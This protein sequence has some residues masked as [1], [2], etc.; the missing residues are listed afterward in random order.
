MAEPTK[1]VRYPHISNSGQLAFSYH[2]DIWVADSDGSGARRLTAH[3]ARDTFPRFSPDGKWIAFNSDRMGNSDIWMVPTTGGVP[4]QLTHHSTDDSIQYWTPDG[5]SII[6]TTS[7]GAGPWGSPLYVVPTDGGLPEPLDMDRAAA[8]MMSQDGK[9]IAFNRSGFRY[10][11]KH[12]RGN[13]NTDIWIQNLATKKISQLT[14]T[15]VKEYRE[16]RQ[17]AHPMWGAD[18]QIY[19]MSERD[20]T[21]NIWKISPDGDE[22]TQVTSHKSDGVQYPSISPDGKTI[23][24]ENEF[25]L[26]KLPIEGGKPE[27]IAIDLSFDPKDNLVHV[28]ESESEARG[29][30]PA[31]DGETV[32]VEFNGEIFIVPADPE[33]GEKVQVTRSEWRDGSVTFSPDGSHLAYMSDQAGDEDIWLYEIETKNHRQLTKQESLKGSMTWSHDSKKIAFTADQKIFL[34]DVAD[35]KLTELIHNPEG[36]FR[37]VDFSN[38]DQWLIYYRSDKDLDSEVYLFDLE[39]RQEHNVTQSRFSEFGNTL[40][41]DGK[42]VVFISDRTGTY[43]LYAVSLTKL[44]EDQDDPLVKKHKQNKKSASS[45]QQT[46]EKPEKDDEEEKA[47]DEGDENMDSDKTKDDDALEDK[48]HSSKQSLEIDLDGIMDRA[49][50]LT[51]GSDDI[52]GYEAS[53][54]GKTI[55]F[56]RGGALYSIG[57]SGGKEKKITDGSFSDLTL[58]GD[59]KSFFYRSGSSLYKM[60]TRGSDKKKI[61]FSLKVRIDK[62]KQWEQIFEEAWRVMKYRFYDEKMHGFDWDE[63]KSRYK[64]MLK[65][66]GENQD[67]YDLCNEMIGELNASHTGVSGPPTRSMDRLVSTRHLGFEMTSDGEYFRVAHIY[68]KGP[69]DKEWLDLKLGDIVLEI[70]GQPIRGNDNYFAILNDLLNDYANITVS[71]PGE[72]DGDTVVLGPERTLR[73]RH[74]SSVRNLK[75]EAWVEGNREYVSEL[76]DGKVGY[77]HIRSMNRSSLERFRTEI[78]QFWNKNGMIIDIRYNGG[79]NIDQELIDILER[80]P[81]EYW[82][83]RQGGRA[84]GRRPRQAIAGPKVMLINWRSASDSEVTPQAFRDLKLGRIVGNPT[85]GAVIATGS[86]GLMGGARIR[87]PGSLVVTYDPTKEYNYGINLE[88]FG[89]PPDVWVENSPK[90]ELKGFD[91]ELKRAVDEALKMLKKGTWQFGEDD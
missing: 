64:P 70:E 11:R 36:G 58:S 45:K 47:T 81:Y 87:T 51:F 27:R 17:D 24:Y 16:H 22:P 1:F 38:D 88:N 65:Y 55:Y 84:R 74:V 20:D 2:G 19:F 78:D 33:M 82:N 91:R 48:D 62:S 71:T 18:G 50:Q 30:S 25:E 6:V 89:V 10:W 73:I 31:P 39:N 67:L 52:R 86:Y 61:E 49:R 69:A 57:V 54:D 9:H 32:A 43:Q 80:K 42:H 8:G 21:F 59:G 60:S 83:S 26:W 76:S 34:V 63:I 12:Y 23:V 5:K 15:K 77:V 68:P 75:Y 90:D 56:T 3:I 72:A 46:D 79:G 35:G 41:S 4:R 37:N 29:M 7:R 13:N 40:T 14:D 53:A 44:T 28:V 85:Y 66:V